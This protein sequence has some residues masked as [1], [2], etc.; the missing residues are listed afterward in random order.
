MTEIAS[1]ASRFERRHRL[2]EPL[3]RSL[4]K[5][6]S[7]T[8]NS[9]DESAASLPPSPVA[10]DNG[11]KIEETIAYMLRHLNQPLKVPQLA[12]LARLSASHYFALF[13]DRTRCSP[14]GYFIRLRMGHACRLLAESSLPVKEIAAQLGYD[15]PFYFSRLFKS[16]HAVAP[17]EYRTT[18]RAGAASATLQPRD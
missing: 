8:F 2:W 1:P 12:S 4:P 14:I 15:D 3:A 9:Q 5:E 17:T 6:R 16:V 11:Q 10:M 7:S 13:K 18:R